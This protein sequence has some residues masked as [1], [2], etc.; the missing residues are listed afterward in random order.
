MFW[1]KGCAGAMLAWS[2]G[3]HILTS[4]L[5]Q[6]GPVLLSYYF[7]VDQAA[8]YCHSIGSGSKKCR[9]IVQVYS[10]GGYK[11]DSGQRSQYI[12]DISWTDTTR[13]EYLYEVSSGSPCSQYLCRSECA[14]QHRYPCT[15]SHRYHVKE[16]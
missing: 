11:W 3:P 2:A 7:L 15:A 10:T 1:L 9:A 4:Q 13:R 5:R 16:K 14:T 6:S 8:P 12:L